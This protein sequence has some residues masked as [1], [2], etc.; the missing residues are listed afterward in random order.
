MYLFLDSTFNLVLGVFTQK[1]HWLQYKA[2]ETKKSSQIIH[3]EIFDLLTSVNLSLRDLD[4]VV[5]IAGPGSYTGMRVSEGIINILEMEGISIFSFYHYEVP[6]ILK[7]SNG[8]F[9][10]KAFKKEF[11]VYAWNSLERGNKGLIAENDLED[12]L[13]SYERR[14]SMEE[15]DNTVST[16]G[17][18]K[19]NIL[20]VYE[21]IMKSKSR[22]PLYYYRSLEEEFKV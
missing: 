15:I 18:I 16:Q 9:Y 3:K 21:Y 10:S 12:K 4:G 5:Y 1:G 8:A 22:V 11:F 20:Q 7:I 19:E 6:Q 13:V 17:L 2:L 14:F